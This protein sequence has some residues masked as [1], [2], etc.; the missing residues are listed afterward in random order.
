MSGQSGW[1]L[2]RNDEKVD[3]LVMV[4]LVG[5]CKSLACCFSLNLLFHAP[6]VM[7]Y[8]LVKYS[9]G[10]ET[11][12]IEWTK[13][14]TC[15]FQ[16][17]EAI[18]HI[19]SQAIGVITSPISYCLDNCSEDLS[20]NVIIPILLTKVVFRHQWFDDLG[21]EWR[22]NSIEIGGRFQVNGMPIV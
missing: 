20:L 10:F 8:H 3:L 18:V 5:S 7:D 21:H 14:S 2:V 11:H 6:L 16:R 22:V 12:R 1:L 19:V 9:D 17:L 15:S 4:R 13:I